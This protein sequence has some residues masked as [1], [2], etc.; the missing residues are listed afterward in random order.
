MAQITIAS[1]VADTWATIYNV[2]KGAMVQIAGTFVGTITIQRRPA[3]S[4][5]PGSSWT[6]METQSIPIVRA[7]DENA[8]AD[9]RV[10]L[11]L[12]GDYTSGSAQC[13]IQSQ[14]AEGA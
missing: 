10:G 3:D 2:Q 1:G 11:V 13:T 4:K 12:A 5:Y 14:S 6:T 8:I 9:Y 7:I